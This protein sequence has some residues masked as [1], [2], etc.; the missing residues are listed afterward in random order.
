MNVL[1]IGVGGFFGAIL[2]YL[3]GMWIPVNNGF[4]L[5]TLIINLLGCFFLGWFFTITTRQL[6]INLQLKLAIGTGFAGAFTTFST[7]SVET[8]NL[9]NNNHFLMALIYLFL[10]IF[11]G[12]GLAF[13]GNKLALSTVKLARE[14]EGDLE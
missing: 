10:S 5:G 4:P 12:V 9:I 8:M 13:T 7:F 2:R 3:V 11:G 6:V 14:I 1:V